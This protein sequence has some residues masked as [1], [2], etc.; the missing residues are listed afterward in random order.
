MTGLTREQILQAPDIR[1]EIL[2]IEEWGGDVWVKSMSGTERDRFEASILDMKTKQT[3]K[4]ENI[5]AKLCSCTLC[6]EEGNLLFTEKDV[7]LLGKKNANALSKVFMLAKALSGI[8]EEEMTDLTSSMK[9][10]F[11]DSASDLPDTSVAP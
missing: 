8:G 11:E 6:D 9:S 2:H 10:P 4:L 5:R 3:V 7:E 1:T